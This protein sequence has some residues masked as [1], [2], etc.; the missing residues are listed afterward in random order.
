MAQSR[1]LK[2]LRWRSCPR[3][4]RPCSKQPPQ[5]HSIGCALQ[6]RR[7]WV[8]LFVRSLYDT[9]GERMGKRSSFDDNAVARMGLGCLAA[10]AATY[11]MDEVTEIFYSEDVARR[12]REV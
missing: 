2:K 12:E 9:K 4:L 11:V 5:R 8:Y 10:V 6:R 3:S 1:P 7:Q